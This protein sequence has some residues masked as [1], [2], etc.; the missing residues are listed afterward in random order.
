LTGNAIFYHF[1][2][3]IMVI[4]IG[5]HGRMRELVRAEAICI[6]RFL[7]LANCETF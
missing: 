5:F 1:I 4:D 3:R 6:E 2:K 7:V